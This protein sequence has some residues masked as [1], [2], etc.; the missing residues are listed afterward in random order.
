MRLVNSPFRIASEARL[1]TTA[2]L[3]VI[4]AILAATP[5]R[6]A[7]IQFP[8]KPSSDSRLELVVEK[9]GLFSG[10]KH[11]FTFDRYSG[12]LLLD[13]ESPERSKV[14]LTIEANS[15]VCHDTWVSMKDLRKI[16]EE[17]TKNMLAADRFPTISFKSASVA[18]A[19]AGKYE[20]HG[21]LT[22]RGTAKP[23]MV[24]VN[25]TPGGAPPFMFAGDAVVKLT[26]YGLKPPTAVLGAIGTRNEMQFHFRLA[27][28]R[29]GADPA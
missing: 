28:K 8:I 24:I 22:I 6:G 1:R 29:E 3:W 14:N 19:G 26:D 16:M 11:V 4:W 15:L 17:G 21:M 12:T 9:T 23:A 27:V 2:V 18:M 7:E 10:K 5:A 13:P 25:W 20:V